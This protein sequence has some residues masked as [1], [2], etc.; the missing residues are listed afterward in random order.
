M[1]AELIKYLWLI[2]LTTSQIILVGLRIVE[3]RNNKKNGNPGNPGNHGERIAKLE[4]AVDNIKDD[5][6]KIDGK[7]EKLQRP[8][9]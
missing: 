5:I 8:G 6:T 2:I 7:L 9:K 3:K 4:E 1:E